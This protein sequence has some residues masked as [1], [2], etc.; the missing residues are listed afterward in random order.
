[1][2][3]VRRLWLLV[4]CVA[5]VAACGQSVAPTSIAVSP[6]AA[7]AVATS[8]TTE[9][10]TP[11]ALVALTPTSSN[12]VLTGQADG[13]PAGCSPNE[14][15][16]RFEAMFR[17]INRGEPNVVDE[18][19]GRKSGASFAWYS[20][21]EFGQTEAD[22]NHFVAYT[23][24]EL[25]AYLK[26]RYQQHEQLQLLSLQFNGWDPGRGL[27]HLG[28]IVITRYAD[29]LRLGLGGPERIAEGKGA[30][31]CRTQAVVAFSLSMERK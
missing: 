9:V 25:D 13:A 12:V 7:I 24:D 19:F 10:P 18:F 30:Y 11:T 27:V 21:T 14:I 2:S 20:M 6:S 8:T 29:D 5:L 1:M 26:R 4:V 17:A 23:W 15:A 22:K 16:R 28:P 3:G 31:H